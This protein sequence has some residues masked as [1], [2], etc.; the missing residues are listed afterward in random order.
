MDKNNDSPSLSI[1]EALNIMTAE[2]NADYDSDVGIE[3]EYEPDEDNSEE[4]DDYEDEESEDSDQEEDLDQDTEL[5]DESDNE[6]EDEE[7]GHVSQVDVVVNGEN[8]KVSLDELKSNYSGKVNYNLKFQELAENRKY[9]EE[10]ARDSVILKAHE[11]MN[12]DSQLEA[13]ITLI[14][15]KFG[16]MERFELY[17]DP[18]IV[19]QAKLINQQLLIQKQ[20]KEQLIEQAN[21]E[22]QELR[23][24]D[25]QTNARE[26]FKENP[27][28]DIE[29][30]RKIGKFL[31]SLGCTD[32][33]ISS[34]STIGAI[35][36][37]MMAIKADKTLQKVRKESKTPKKSDH[38]NSLN[39][40]SG[41]SK[42][43]SSS[44]QSLTF[45][46]ALAM[47]KNPTKRK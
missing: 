36:L 39:K 41:P 45:E 10:K 43:R 17:A 35:R 32:D 44:D 25:L 46:E 47:M 38:R 27:D 19:Q 29:D 12:I 40:S 15:E 22:I 31:R 11:L 34:F 1:S 37:A 6:D 30:F 16:Q 20:E 3:D 33:E 23:I 4:V 8:I 5:D 18:N 24:K 9:F 42:Q 13:N 26:Y 14:N 21:K 7:T 2:D 28:A